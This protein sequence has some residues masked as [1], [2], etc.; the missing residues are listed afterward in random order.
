[1]VCTSVSHREPRPMLVELRDPW[2]GFLLSSLSPPTFHLFKVHTPFT[3]YVPPPRPYGLHVRQQPHDPH[4]QPVITL[5]SLFSPLSESAA[6]GNADVKSERES[7]AR[8]LSQVSVIPLSPHPPLP[9]ALVFS[10][11]S[12]SLSGPVER[13]TLASREMERR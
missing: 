4:S 2:P 3:P 11:P 10:S 9:P 8:S 1:M 7:K 12:P 13:V 5:P 6:E